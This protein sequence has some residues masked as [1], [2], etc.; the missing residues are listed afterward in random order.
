VLE[1]SF[2]D[3]MAM[4]SSGDICDGK[5]IMLLQYAALNIF[6]ATSQ[7]MTIGGDI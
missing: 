2:S 1:L 6:N 5:T 7:S 3:A 4:V